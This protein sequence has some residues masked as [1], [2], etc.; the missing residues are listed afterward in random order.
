[1]SNSRTI[2]PDD[3]GSVKGAARAPEGMAG[4][5]KGLAV[6]EAFGIRHPQLTVTDAA[7]RTNTSRAAARRCLLTL[8]ELGYLTHDNGNFRPT[9]RML[10]LGGAYL[11]TAPL[12]QLAQPQL[13]EA[14]DALGESVSLAVLEDGCSLFVARA[15]AARIVATGVRVGAKLPAHSSATGRVLLAGLP[16]TQLDDYLRECHPQPRTPKTLTD[17]DAISERILTARESGVACT[18]EEIELGMLSIAVPVRTARGETVAAMSVSASTARTTLHD[19]RE[20]AVPV[21]N[22]YAARLGRLL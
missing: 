10:R 14:R 15:E 1:M 18:D 7:Q 9:P 17:V 11:D 12:P 21:L 13:V 8:V 22:K 2:K 5:A 6:I 3:K 16:D 19:I 4:L 20:A